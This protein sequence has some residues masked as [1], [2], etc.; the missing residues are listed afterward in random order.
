[1]Y[2]IA[3]LG[4]DTVLG[5]DIRQRIMQSNRANQIDNQAEMDAYRLPEETLI[6]VAQ[7]QLVDLGLLVRCL[8][9]SDRVLLLDI[10]DPRATLRV[11]EAMA[12]LDKAHLITVTPTVQQFLLTKTQQ[13]REEHA[14]ILNRNIAMSESLLRESG[15]HVTFIDLPC[16]N[17]QKQVEDRQVFIRQACIAEVLNRVE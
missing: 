13:E 2:T 12:L 8:Q 15:L 5:H 7:E 10:Q 9:K 6:E 14:Q 11:I 4:A 3:L 16:G 17:K 1:M